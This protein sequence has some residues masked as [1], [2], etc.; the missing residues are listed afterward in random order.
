M[1]A[2]TT[3]VLDTSRG[4]PAANIPA[5]L[6][7]LSGAPSTWQTLAVAAT[8]ADGRI[9]ALLPSGHILAAGIYRLTF[10]TAGYFAA[11]ATETFYPKVEILFTV[12]D[13]LQHY[14]VPL[15]LSAFG[16]ST[17]RGS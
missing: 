4:K 17:Y 10:E 2:I 16:Y 15:L 9:P 13:P 12:R 3:H 1:S 8:N 5:T 14:H 11:S 7:Y 6:D